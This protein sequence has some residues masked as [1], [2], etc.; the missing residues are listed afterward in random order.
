VI[1]LAAPGCKCG[2]TE[3][4]RADAAQSEPG[5][6]GSLFSGAPGADV[7]LTRLVDLGKHGVFL[8][9]PK[10]WGG[11]E[12]H[13]SGLVT[14]SPSDQSAVATVYVVK[15]TVSDATI[16]LWTKSSRGSDVS[17]GPEQ[18]GRIGK[19][20]LSGQMANGMGKLAGKD[21]EFWRFVVPLGDDANVLVIAAVQKA[22]ELHRRAELIA[23]LRSLYKN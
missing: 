21:A 18:P 6:S 1:A 5:A 9:V 2:H 17:Y 11:D 20:G 15:G 8:S 16:A 13:V 22:A 10:G 23:C 4:T 14:L 3:E 7:E 12:D 19:I